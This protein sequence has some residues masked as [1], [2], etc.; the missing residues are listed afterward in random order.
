M[1]TNSRVEE[2]ARGLFAQESSRDK[3]HKIGASDFSN[4]CTYHVASKLMGIPE[5]PSKYWLG[6]K[7]GTATHE[8]FE[9]RIPTADFTEFPE[10]ED[11]RIEEKIV[12]GNLKDYGEIKS[13]PDLMLV[14]NNHLIDWK[15]STRKKSK[16]FQALIYEG[17]Q[18][19]DATYTL[20]KYFAQV[21][22]YAWGL[23]KSGLS[24]D[25]CSLVFVNRD[26]TGDNDV[27]AYTFDY[28][29]EYALE[30]WH[31]L[32]N[33]WLEVQSGK[34]LEEFERHQ[35]CFSCSMEVR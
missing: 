2:I 32:E 15:T 18:D 24:V 10:L 5:S 30:I 20:Q 12:L 23:N 31:R 9:K 29:E 28:S 3:Q 1:L 25:G 6:G 17:S 16:A 21:Q 4:P 14:R 11:V 19:T 8:F 33:I 22:I 26:G 7:L 35:S 27:W 13:K 34:P